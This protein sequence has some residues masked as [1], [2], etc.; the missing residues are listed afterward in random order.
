MRVLSLRQWGLDGGFASG[1]VV[2]AALA[3]GP[4]ITW[5][6]VE[7]SWR[8]LAFLVLAALLPILLRW[9]VEVAF[10]AY[11]FF[12]P[13]DTVAVVAST[14]G[15]TITR[16]VGIVAAAVLLVS[17]LIERRLVR[18]P[19]AAFWVVLLFIWA[20]ATLGWAIDFD[21]ARARLP[22]A[23]SLLA[24]YLA[25]VSFK[26]SGRH[27]ATVCVLTMLGGIVAATAGVILGFDSEAPRAARGTLAAGG[28]EANPN[29]VAMGLLLP[30]AVALVM[31]MSSRRMWV[32][33][34]AVVAAG[35]ISAGIFLTMSR[36]GVA[37]VALMLCVLMYRYRVR[38]QLLAVVG[39]LAA[40]LA[41]MPDAFFDRVGRVFTGEDA[42]G[43]GR[44]EIWKVGLQ[45]LPQFGWLGA[46]LANFTSA[47][48]LY[49]PVPVLA[50][51][52]GPHNTYLATWVE[53]GVLGLAL[54][55]AAVLAHVRTSNSKGASMLPAG[56]PT[57]I[58]AVCIAFLL[59]AFFNGDVL[60]KK[61]FWMAWILAIWSW[62]ARGTY[63]PSGT[64]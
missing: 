45:M 39:V 12:I 38:W 25:A 31:L 8:I 64:A 57:A 2:V 33:G 22:T 1:I 20:I 41:V 21:L 34:V 3:L 26:P 14:G 7:E 40:V 36:A 37:A 49:A 29:I 6:I 55:L 58:E 28:I 54:F 23:L 19:A 13:L 35:A 56:F 32:K 4:L 17:G 11:A 10:G 48:E 24:L 30:L 62:R 42:T 18:P 15:T 16:M 53:L 50:S 51:A 60:Y 46:G 43:S 9:P 44:T 47:Y 52:P 5:A 61:P 59:I 27:L 63:R